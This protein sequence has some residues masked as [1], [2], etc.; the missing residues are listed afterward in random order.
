LV[1]IDNKI[2]LIKKIDSKENIEKLKK[3]IK[4]CHEEFIPYLI[5]K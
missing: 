3:E 1:I 5:S 4:L 2:K